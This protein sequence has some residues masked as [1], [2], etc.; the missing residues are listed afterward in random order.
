MQIL[1][2]L[3]R[4]QLGKLGSAPCACGLYP[5]AG[6]LELVHKAAGPGSERKREGAGEGLAQDPLDSRLRTDM[7]S[8][9]PHSI[10]QI[11][12]QDYPG[13]MSE[14]RILLNKRCCKVI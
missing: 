4:S 6:Q 11:K 9:L 14:K 13:F 3:G 2:D 8:L 10:G 12:S 1:A 5:P 7:M